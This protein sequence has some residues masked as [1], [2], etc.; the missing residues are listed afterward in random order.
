[1]LFSIGAA[2]DALLMWQ[3]YDG[4]SRAITPNYYR[5]TV[6]PFTVSHLQVHAPHSAHVQAVGVH[7]SSRSGAWLWAGQSLSWGGGQTARGRGRVTAARRGI[8]R[9]PP[10]AL[11]TTV[12]CSSRECRVRW[13]R[14]QTGHYPPPDWPG[15]VPTEPHGCTKWRENE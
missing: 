15:W 10:A 2:L 13:G 12:H 6:R 8:D 3:K 5:W 9:Y 11:L 7:R 4:T 1:M 14:A